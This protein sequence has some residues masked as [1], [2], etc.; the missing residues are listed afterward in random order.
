M[1]GIYEKEPIFP[2]ERT[3]EDNTKLHEKYDFQGTNTWNKA[4]VHI[5]SGTLGMEFFSR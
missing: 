4:G 3:W 1:A 5:D 2:L